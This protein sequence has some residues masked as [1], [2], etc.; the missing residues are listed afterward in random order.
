MVNPILAAA[1]SFLIP[2][3]G[4]IAAGDVKRGIN[5]L[6]VLVLID[7]IVFFGVT[8]T[9]RTFLI[10]LILRTYAAYDT[11]HLAN[12]NPFY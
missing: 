1:L 9:S 11:Y 2:G 3:M 4:Q 6:V 7:L 8:T 10:S 5:F 12:S